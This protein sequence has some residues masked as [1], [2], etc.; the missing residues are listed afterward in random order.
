MRKG[1][2]LVEVIKDF[3]FENPNMAWDPKKVNK[4]ERIFNLVNQRINKKNKGQNRIFN[5]V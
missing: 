5:G 4:I 2:D 1:K 3:T